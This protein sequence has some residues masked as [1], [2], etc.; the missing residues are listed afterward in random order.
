MHKKQNNSILCIIMYF[1][2]W[3]SAHWGI[4]YIIIQVS[5]FNKTKQL[6]PMHYNSYVA[7]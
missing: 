6:Y 5:Y 7:S 1:M 3:G 2:P 4:K